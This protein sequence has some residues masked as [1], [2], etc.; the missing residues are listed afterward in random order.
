M[1]QEPYPNCYN[2]VGFL[3]MVDVPNSNHLHFL[4]FIS[5]KRPSIKRP[6]IAPVADQRD[7]NENS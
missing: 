5:I 3:G 7:Q 4:K 1:H 6:S 2:N